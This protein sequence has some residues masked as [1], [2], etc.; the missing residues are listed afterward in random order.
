M[1]NAAENEWDG[2]PPVDGP[3]AVT[4]NYIYAQTSLDVDNVPKPILDALKELVHPD[5][6]Q[7]FDL[8]CHKRSS[9][10]RMLALPSATSL[11]R[12]YADSRGEFVH[13]LVDRADVFRGVI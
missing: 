2:S 6:D 10:G 13:V 3:V 9:R 12:R 8:V 1:R 4:I 5:D 7:V 11:L